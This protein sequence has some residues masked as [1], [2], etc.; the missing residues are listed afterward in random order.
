ML[1]QAKAIL[2]QYYGYREFRPGQEQVIESLLGGR[3]TLAI[4]PT[5]AGKSVC[6]Q[7]PALLLDGLTIV[8]SPLISLMKDQ[9]DGLVDQ[10]IA[11]TY[12]NSSLSAAV[13]SD[14]LAALQGG[15]YKLLYVAPERLEAES[16]QQLLRQLPVR[17]VAVDEAHCVSQWGHDFRPSYK[18]VAAFIQSLPQRPLIGAFTATATPEVKTDMVRLLGL[19]QPA[20]YVTGFD[21]PNLSFS[22]L[23]GEDKRQFVE[24][25]VAAHREQSGIIYAATRR[26]VDELYAFLHKQGIAAGHYHAGLSE[27]ER[28][29]Q[30]EAFLYDDIRV[31]VA[32]NAFG[33]GIDKSN[34]RYVIHYNMPKNMEAYYQEAGRSGRDGEPGEC[35]LLFA[36]QDVMLQ[37]YLIDKSVESEDRSQNELAKLQ[38]MV[39]YCYTPEC[40]RHYILSY[41]GETEA[42]AECRNCSNCQD[43][44]ERVDITVDAQKVFSCVYRMKERFGVTMVAEVLKGSKNQKLLE[45]GLHELS[46]YALFKQRKLGDIKTLIQ[47]LLATGYLDLSEGQFPVVRLTPQAYAVLR[48]QE[49]VWQ[50]TFV[51]A[52]PAPQ[53]DNSLFEALRQVR[54]ELAQQAGIPPYLVFND[55]TLREMS[56]LCPTDEAA[57]AKIKGVGERKLAQYG[58]AFL[59]AIRQYQL[60]P[61]S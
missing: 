2:Q 36:Q 48:N 40:L 20:V 9:V 58:A 30:Q 50:K 56:S 6:F 29:T 25:Y 35:I 23:R 41:F 43:T 49:T 3:D 60:N 57:L 51:Q 53:E 14:R 11:A 16:F 5:G 37:K 32:T 52:A 4:M 7:V 10:G 54:R 31:M 39:D 61:H 22:V 12:I 18:A 24:Q 33:M 59:T 19:R 45:L 26:E 13:T 38:D 42:A 28:T 47:R 1:E 17:L 8:V 34:V 15:H 21:R 27:E 55:S 44:S 46:T